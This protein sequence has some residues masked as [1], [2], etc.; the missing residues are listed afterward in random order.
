MK[1][2]F[3]IAAAFVLFV[4]ILFGL[5]NLEL[6]NKQYFGTRSRAI[7]S[8]I[9]KQ[10]EQYN[11]GMVRDLYNFKMEYIN[12]DKEKKKAIRGVL[13]HRFSVYPKEN[14]PYDLRNF[15]LELGI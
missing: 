9:F 7:D 2:L 10:S 11:D 13:M 5:G 12:G 8:K 1:E 14:L 3:S 4:L 6:F 15:L